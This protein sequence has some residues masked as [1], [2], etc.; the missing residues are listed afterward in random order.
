M[1]LIEHLMQPEKLLITWQAI[2]PS[3]NQCAGKRFVVGEVR[4]ENGDWVLGYY[5]NDDTAEAQR[6][7]LFKGLTAFPYEASKTYTSNVENVL[8]KRIASPRR[9]DYADYLRSYRIPPEMADSLSTMQVLAYTGGELTGDGFVFFPDLENMQPPFDLVMVIAGFRHWE[10]MNIGPIME[11]M[12]KEV[13]F[14]PE[15]DNEKDPFAIEVFAGDTKLGYLPRGYNQYFVNHALDSYN[16]TA[17][18][19]KINGTIERPKIS[20]LAEIKIA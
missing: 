5:D 7:F 18:I 10:G 8:S 19:T 20:I 17:C 14:V 15:P 6:D 9:A 13:R 2:D 12:D 4:A 3:N 11:L 16:I 1:K